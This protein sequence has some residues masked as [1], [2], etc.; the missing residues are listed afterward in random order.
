MLPGMPDLRSR[1]LALA[2]FVDEL[3]APDFDAGHW[4]PMAPTR[5]DPSVSTMPWYEL[6]D[7]ALAF[8]GAVGANGW[9][10]PFDWMAWAQTEEGTALREDRDALADA[11][12]DQLQRLLTTLIRADRFSE[13]TLGWAFETGLMAA[14]AR[15]AE[16]LAAALSLDDGRADRS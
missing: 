2:V 9:V 7:R 13:G 1:L 5:D 11:T 12:P 10:E 15:R 4:H 14:I 8:V 16:A 3:D 6:S